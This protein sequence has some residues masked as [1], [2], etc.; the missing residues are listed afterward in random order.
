MIRE[1]NSRPCRRASLG[2]HLAAVPAAAALSPWL[3][4]CPSPST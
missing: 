3:A 2:Y 4:P 1:Q